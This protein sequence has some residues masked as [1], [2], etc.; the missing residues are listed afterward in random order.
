M[1]CIRWFILSSFMKQAVL[2][3]HSHLQLMVSSFSSPDDRKTSAGV[4]FVAGDRQYR[5]VTGTNFIGQW[6][7]R[8]HFSRHLQ[9]LKTLVWEHH[10]EEIVVSH[11][12]ISCE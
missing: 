7:K 9:W 11:G 10:R 12:F 1:F 5:Q 2:G 3:L 6:L 8:K 4:L